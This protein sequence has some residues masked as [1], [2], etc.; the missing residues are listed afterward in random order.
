MNKSIILFGITSQI[1]RS[2][3]CRYFVVPI[4]F[5]DMICLSFNRYLI[6]QSHI[7]LEDFILPE[8]VSIRNYFQLHCL[9]ERSK[10]EKASSLLS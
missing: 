5:S 9:D 6:I 7:S 8:I 10:V 3:F 4:E 1:V 2:V